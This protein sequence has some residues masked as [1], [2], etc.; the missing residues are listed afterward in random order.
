MQTEASLPTLSAYGVKLKW[1]VILGLTGSWTPWASISLIK[2]CNV[3][4]RPTVL[5][6]KALGNPSGTRHARPGK[7]G[8]APLSSPTNDG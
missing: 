2:R 6:V 5:V 7:K 8:S 3:G 1:Q 4:Q